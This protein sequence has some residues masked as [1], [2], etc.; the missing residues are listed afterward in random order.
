MKDKTDLILENSTKTEEMKKPLLHTVYSQQSG[1]QVDDDVTE[2]VPGGGL[3]TLVMSHDTNCGS[4]SVDSAHDIRSMVAEKTHIG[5]SSVDSSQGSNV[6][7]TENGLLVGRNEVS[8]QLM[9]DRLQAQLHIQTEAMTRLQ[10]HAH[11]QQAEANVLTTSLRAR[12][13]RRDNEMKKLQAQHEQLMRQFLSRVLLLEGQIKR[14]HGEILELLQDKDDVIRRQKAAIED[15]AEKNDRLLQVISQGYAT[16]NGV[17]KAEHQEPGDVSIRDH[18]NK[19]VLRGN[20]T[21]NVEK[22]SSKVRFSAMKERLRR[23]KS[24]LELYSS[25]PLEPLDEGGL[26]YSSQENLVGRNSSL[27]NFERKE[28]CRSLVDYPFG[29]RD[30]DENQQESPDSCFGDEINSPDLPNSVHSSTSSLVNMGDRSNHRPS[31]YGFNELSKSRSV[32]HALPTVSE[33]VS[34]SFRERPHSLPSVDLLAKDVPTVPSSSAPSATSGNTPTPAPATPS[35]SPPKSSSESNPFQSIKNVFKRRGSKKKKAGISGSQDVN[36][37]H[38]ETLKQH[39][40]K[41]NL[42]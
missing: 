24:S 32:P 31:S 29:L 1:P 40:K 17:T 14:E 3:L 12:L 4:R 30:V 42:T 20:K 6:D 37:E 21:K 5:F 11:A 19:V 16:D 28:R 39:F 34:K 27:R 26:R 25:A 9:I 15:L 22:V 41:Y 10:A 36:K 13:R 38:S 7:Q 18:G 8:P 33:H 35:Q 2:H 23:H